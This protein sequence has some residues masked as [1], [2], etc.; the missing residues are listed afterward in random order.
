M[1]RERKDA[2]V[3]DQFGQTNILRTRDFVF[4][5]QRQRQVTSHESKLLDVQC[6][7]G[8]CFRTAHYYVATL[9]PYSLVKSVRTARQ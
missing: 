6:G 5:A 3:V 1:T 7:R 8:T 4:P 9:A 2:M